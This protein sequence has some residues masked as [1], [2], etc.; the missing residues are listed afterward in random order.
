[1]MRLQRSIPVHVSVGILALLVAACGDSNGGG[2]TEPTADTGSI[3]ASAMT[4]GNDLDPDG[5]TVTVGSASLSLSIN[6]T[7]TFTGVTTGSHSVQLSGV[8]ANCEAGTNPQS[9]T[10]QADQTTSVSFAVVCSGE[11]LTEQAVT[12][13]EDALFAAINALQNGTVDDLDQFSFE[14]TRQFFQ[15][16]VDE[17][18]TNET[19]QFGLAITTIFVME[20][21]SEIRD[22]ADRWDVWLQ[23]HSIDDLSGIDLLGAADP[24]FW[25]RASLP[26]DMRGLP[27]GRLTDFDQMRRVLI[28]QQTA[29]QEFPPTLSEHQNLLRD[30]I[31]PELVGALTA[32]NA[33]ESPQFVFIITE[34]MQGET[35]A[36]ADPLELDLTEILALRAVLEG[37]LALVDAALAYVAEPSPWGAAGFGA[38]FET[39]STFATLASDG[40]ELLLDAQERVVRGID[41]LEQGL[42]NLVAETD[43]QSNDIIKY[44]PTGFGGFNEDD[45]LNSQ[46]VQDARDFL[47]DAKA[48]VQGPRTVTEDF[49]L[50]EVALVVDASKFFTDPIQDL[51]TLLPDYEVMNGKFR[52]AALTMEEWT[53]PDPTFHGILPEMA[54]NTQLLEETL[55]LS[56]LYR[57]H[58]FP[59][60]NWQD[61]AF[62]PTSGYLAF[63][64]EGFLGVVSADLASVTFAPTLEELMISYDGTAIA[65]RTATPEIIAIGNDGRVFARP[66]DDTSPWTS[67]LQT[68]PADQWVA[69]AVRSGGVFALSANGAVVEIDGGLTTHTVL[70]P[71]G[72][73]SGYAA[74]T[75]SGSHLVAIAYCGELFRTLD[76]SSVGWDAEMILPAPNCDWKALAPG[77]A[78]TT[79]AG[80][81]LGE[82]RQ[83]SADF[84]SSQVLPSLPLM[85]Y[86]LMALATNE[87]ASQLVAITN[88]GRLYSRPTDDPT[89]P[90]VEHPQIPR[91]RDF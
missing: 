91:V 76:P 80:S 34:R 78:G 15:Q 66:D 62:S 22:L 83:I 57:E 71:I 44:D 59:Q 11:T 40:A 48:A 6:G 28:P 45:G 10:V 60:G 51:K 49:G 16:A 65:V 12:S 43:D 69:L 74:M 63:A 14:A 38:A 72:F 54:S 36:E 27:L 17:D 24:F 41:L 2:G 84:S 9:A 58:A 13:L 46:D 50:G 87:D 37:S 88:E 8:A 1:M 89:A 35:P 82:V 52:W 79:F 7:V 29:L 18:P 4:T 20:D 70:P 23:T 86:G 75:A 85:F 77:P 55:D 33:I 67:S 32:L 19:A 68:L 81:G 25:P 5:Y 73:S 61:M 30:V 3:T 31:Q 39:G 47:A 42:D 21:H 53:F 64:T 26:L 90:W 56:D